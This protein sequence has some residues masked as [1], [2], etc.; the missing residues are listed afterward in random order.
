MNI[1]FRY[2]SMVRTGLVATM[3]ACASMSA[4][5]LT[6]DSG[7]DGSDGALDF[8]WAIPESGFITIE[9]DPSDA[10]TF[11]PGNPDRKLDIDNDNI[12]HFTSITIPANVNVQ[13]TAPKFNW[14]PVYWLSQGDISINLKGSLD[15]RGSDGH[16]MSTLGDGRF[17]AIPGPGG[18]PGGVGVSA[19]NMATPGFGPGAG[20]AAGNDNFGGGGSHAT[21]GGG[22]ILGD[23]YGS[24]FLLPL[25]GGSGG[26]GGGDS[27]AV[28]NISR[29]GGGAGG[30]AILLASNTMI[31]MD[32]DIYLGGGTGGGSDQF[33]YGGGN[34][35][36]G[37]LRILTPVF[38]GK[39][40][41]NQPRHFHWGEI[42]VNGGNSRS[43]NNRYGYS[44]GVGRVRI[45]TFDNQFTGKFFPDATSS[46]RISGLVPSTPFLPTDN[47]VPGWP[48][49]HVTSVNSV[50]VNPEPTGSFS[51]PDTTVSVTT[52]VPV[53]FEAKN[54]PITANLKLHIYGPDF[55]PI[56][57]EPTFSSGS[58]TLSTWTAD[59][60]FP[61]GVTRAYL[62]AT[63]TP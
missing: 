4:Q 25:V 26:A 63:W 37:A 13:L 39:Y 48:S 34:G 53:L 24:P 60:A 1:N 9:L 32:G 51:L 40:T 20:Q 31:I 16:A 12:F 46:I 35:S 18:F 57:V 56:V 6:F 10:T 38:K 19:T 28:Q 8:T 61:V 49:V 55:E 14:A 11:D 50:A 58:D 5:A 7:S 59:V 22:T 36:G 3:L 27:V 62:Q 29:G 30:G 45:E 43:N 47:R 54:V 42:H 33:Q 41:I 2:K 17:P 44:G 21:Q 23:I 52:T 15:L